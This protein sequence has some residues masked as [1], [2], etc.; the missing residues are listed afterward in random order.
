MW[1]IAFTIGAFVLGPHGR[2]VV[3]QAAG[4]VGRRRRERELAEAGKPA[5]AL[6]GLVEVA[7][8]VAFLWL[9]VAKPGG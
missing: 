8:I 6:L 2:R 1:A 5:I 7:F 9:M 3:R 4:L